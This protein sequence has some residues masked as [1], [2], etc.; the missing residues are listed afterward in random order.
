M[1][2]LIIQLNHASG[3][4]PPDS[5]GKR[6]KEKLGQLGF[7][8]QVYLREITQAPFG[9]KNLSNKRLHY[10]MEKNE[11][12]D[13]RKYAKEQKAWY[14]RLLMVRSHKKDFLGSM[15]DFGMPGVDRQGC[16]IYV[17]TIKD[18]V[19]SSKLFNKLTLRTSLHEMGHVFN[20]L[21]PENSDNS[22]MVQT[23]VL[24]KH[25]SWPNNI[26][27]KYNENDIQF[28]KLNTNDSAKP[29]SGVP[30][31]GNS[32]NDILHLIK[33]KNRKKSIEISLNITQAFDGQ[34]ELGSALDL[35]IKIKN[36]SKKTIKLKSP[37]GLE[38]E[39]IVLLIEN[40]HNGQFSFFKSPVMT[41]GSKED[42]VSLAPGESICIAEPIFLDRQ[43]FVF[44][45]L[46][47]YKL[48]V[49]IRID[50]K[51]YYWYISTPLEIELISTDKSIEELAYCLF[52]RQ[53][54]VYLYLQGAD[55][56][57]ASYRLV[58]KAIN[59]HSKSNH[60]AP[61]IESIANINYSQV[62]ENNLSISNRRA[63]N[64]LKLS[65]DGFNKVLELE[66]SPIKC[67]QVA[68]KII[69]LYEKNDSKSEAIK[70]MK[71]YSK[72]IEAYSEFNV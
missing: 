43:G 34:V 57:T 10:L 3:L 37:L 15:F 23:N 45:E 56:L 4:I 53:V 47:G 19:N 9:V 32:P 16:A 40:C 1:R 17:D 33:N 35:L 59:M 14:A 26:T 28:C 60:I 25:P 27:Y 44:N 63:Q 48:Y 70:I 7:E 64:K 11:D 39:N 5:W 52:N 24:Y 58:K 51:L 66:K 8:S 72:E 13:L 36:K 38:G 22:I 31:R 61:L 2:K 49:A 30:F 69:K 42:S 12:K 29:G 21:H 46:C 62:F 71:N 18:K 20:F 50:R 65:I 68:K 54:G 55:H 6:F 67:G 41:C